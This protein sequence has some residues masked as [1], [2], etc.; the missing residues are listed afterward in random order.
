MY[1]RYLLLIPERLLRK[2]NKTDCLLVIG[3]LDDRHVYRDTVV[4]TYN[5]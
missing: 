1:M 3:E 2:H 4:A 5:L